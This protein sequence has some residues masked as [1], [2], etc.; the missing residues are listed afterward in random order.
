MPPI[1]VF[2]GGTVTS[3]PDPKNIKALHARATLV[4]TSHVDL[5]IAAR[6]ASVDGTIYGLVSRLL[7]PQTARQLSPNNQLYNNPHEWLNAL[8]LAAN[9]APCLLPRQPA[10]PPRQQ[11]VFPMAKDKFNFCLAIHDGQVYRGT[12]TELK[13][14][15]LEPVLF[16]DSPMALHMATYPAPIAQVLAQHLT[17]LLL[18]RLSST[19]AN[20]KEGWYQA[21]GRVATLVTATKA[22]LA[23]PVRLAK[24]EKKAK[25]DVAWRAELLPDFQERLAKLPPQARLIMLELQLSEEAITTT[26]LVTRLSG[27]LTTRQPVERVVNYYRPILIKHGL[28]A[29][30][31]N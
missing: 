20:N 22:R 6:A 19:N 31:A 7:S 14:A 18:S 29:T 21:L 8:L 24:P 17:P 26:Q 16:L 13:T 12:E 30:T 1:L 27:K 25:G 11:E 5:L 3:C 15:I 2:Q 10:N 9:Q 4:V 28:L 23:G